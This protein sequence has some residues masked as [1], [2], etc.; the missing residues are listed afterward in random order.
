MA[1]ARATARTRRATKRAMKRAMKEARMAETESDRH[2]ETLRQENPMKRSLITAIVLSLLMAWTPRA[3]RAGDED[4][5]KKKE[6][7]WKKLEEKQKKG[8]EKPGEGGEGGD[9]NAQGGPD[10]LGDNP[11]LK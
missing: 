1:K 11:L 2:H 4:E 8:G 9:P 5:Q 3:A 7:A 6:K 10:G